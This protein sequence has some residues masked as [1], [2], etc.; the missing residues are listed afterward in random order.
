MGLCNHFVQEPCMHQF[1]FLSMLITFTMFLKCLND[2][3]SLV[4]VEDYKKRGLFTASFK[5]FLSVWIVYLFCLKNVKEVSTTA[6]G[7]K[8]RK[9]KLNNIMLKTSEDG[10]RSSCIYYPTTIQDDRADAICC[11]FVGKFFGVELNCSLVNIM[12]KN[13]FDRGI[14]KG[15]IFQNGILLMTIF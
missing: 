12:I 9:D 10:F 15:I 8:Y 5:Q 1:I 3:N 13:G 4:F 2:T 6:S 7:A 14:Y 11:I